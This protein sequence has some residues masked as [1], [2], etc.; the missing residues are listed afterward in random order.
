MRLA[1]PQQHAKTGGRDVFQVFRVEHDGR[2]C[3]ALQ[4]GRDLLF[5]VR[6]IFGIDAAADLNGGIGAV[7]EKTD[8]VH[9]NSCIIR[10]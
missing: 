1:Q 9:K 6:R 10:S 4:A 5:D 2:I 3:D 7:F 8:L